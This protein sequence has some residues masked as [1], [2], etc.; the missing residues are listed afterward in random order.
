MEKWKSSHFFFCSRIFCG[1]SDSWLGHLISVH[2]QSGFGV[3]SQESLGGIDNSNIFQHT[4]KTS[5]LTV[6]Q[7]AI[8]NFVDLIFRFIFLGIIEEISTSDKTSELFPVYFWIFI[9][10]Y[11]LQNVQYNG[12]SGWYLPFHG[13]H[14]WDFS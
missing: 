8:K 10:I 2:F 1:G 9:F 12:C 11:I 5:D 4:T 13:T 6:E 3:D 7:Y 14:F